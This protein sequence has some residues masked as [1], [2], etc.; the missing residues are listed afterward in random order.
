MKSLS[1]KLTIGTC[2][3][4]ILLAEGNEPKQLK[5]LKILKDLGCEVDVAS[6][7]L[8]ALDMY[9]NGYDVIIA[10]SDLKNIDSPLLARIIYENR[11]DANVALITTTSFANFLRQINLS[12]KDNINL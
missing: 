5:Q 6:S 2:P 8:L 7:G 1:K 11:P 3:V 9:D 4:K 12:Q 10:G